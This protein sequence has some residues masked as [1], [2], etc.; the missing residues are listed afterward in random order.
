MITYKLTRHDSRNF[1]GWIIWEC[2]D[3]M[4]E[5]YFS[6]T[7]YEEARAMYNDLQNEQ[8]QVYS[9]NLGVK[10]LILSLAFSYNL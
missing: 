2:S 3:G 10:H 5:E 6:T 9:G 1:H 7:S 8:T 4:E